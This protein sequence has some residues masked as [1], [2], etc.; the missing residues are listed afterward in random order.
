VCGTK[1]RSVY[2]FS[3]ISI[4]FIFFWFYFRNRLKYTINIPGVD[5]AANQPRGLVAASSRLVSA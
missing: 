5:A 1:G 3:N 2:F 4:L